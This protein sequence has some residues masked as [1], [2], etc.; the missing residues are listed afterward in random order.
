MAVDEA[1]VHELQR[2]QDALKHEIQELKHEGYEETC[3]RLERELYDLKKEGKTMNGIAP[4]VPLGNG[5][6][7]GGDGGTLMGLILG[8]A[9]GGGGFGGFGNRCGTAAGLTEAAVINA[10]NAAKDATVAEIT[11]INGNL[12]NANNFGNVYRTVDNAAANINQNL[13][14]VTT[15]LA[16]QNT[17]IQA[18]I[19]EVRTGQASLA[20]ASA[21]Q[22]T[23]ILQALC[24]EGRITSGQFAQLTQL[25]NSGFAAQALEMAKC[26]CETNRNIDAVKFEAQR[27]T[28]LLSRQMAEGFCA[29]NMNITAAKQ[30]LKD[31]ITGNRMCDME[32]EILSLRGENS[33]MRQTA[34]I[35]SSLG[36]PTP[37][38]IG[39][40]LKAAA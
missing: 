27:N 24:N 2:G 33:Q 4:V 17:F 38:P 10:T 5:N 23:Q 30:E 31:L 8:A 14:L 7:W 34:V 11:S 26:C 21:T 12:A 40:A 28:D 3:N 13:G 25:V 37:N 18:G 22:T 16:D 19:A 39:S 29:T 32:K 6:G 35:L 20:A 9:L 36:V 1:G 15:R